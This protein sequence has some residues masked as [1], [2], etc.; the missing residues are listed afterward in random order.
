MKA[1]FLILG[2]LLIGCAAAGGGASGDDGGAYDGGDDDW[3]ACDSIIN[4]FDECSPGAN[5]PE[6]SQVILQ[7]CKK[8][9]NEPSTENPYQCDISCAAENYD[10]EAGA[11]DCDEFKTCRNCC[12]HPQDPGC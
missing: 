8:Y 9:L 5:T 6:Q 12:I 1:L 4:A 2:L 10:Q 3:T 11:Y 7:D